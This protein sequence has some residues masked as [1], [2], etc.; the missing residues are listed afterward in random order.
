MDGSITLLPLLKR[1]WW[2]LALGAL[3]AGIGGY[4]IASRA[5]P[6]YKGEVKLLVGPINADAGELDAA[7]EIGRTYSELAASRP[8]LESAIQ[9][10]RAQARAE[11]LAKRVSATSNE[12]SRIVSI[13][14]EHGD[15][16]AA[17]ALAN[18]IAERLQEISE[19]GR[20]K[21]SDA[22]REFM[23]AA[24]ISSLDDTDRSEVRAAARR[25][26]ATT[27]AG[28]VTVV[29]PAL[30]PSTPVGPHVPMMTLLAALAGLL[31][32]G[33]IVVIRDSSDAEGE[34]KRDV[35]EVPEGLIDPNGFESLLV[36]DKR[37]GILGTL[38]ATT[39]K[40]K[41]E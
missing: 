9:K 10:A 39:A 27:G 14:V 19:E 36:D 12:I 2:A 25:E 1:W 40:G 6:T 11:D 37:S 5:A 22:V 13:G 28:R 38:K 15:P 21:E 34:S 24:E 23:K 41:R 3:I 29:D 35:I 17:A 31:A 4:V 18:A 32:V 20:E 30:E 16:K 8:V 26:F 7:G 33:L